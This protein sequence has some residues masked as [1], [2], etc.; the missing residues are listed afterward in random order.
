V[1]GLFVGRLIELRAKFIV[2]VDE[3]VHH[4]E[5]VGQALAGRQPQHRAIPSVSPSIRRFIGFFGLPLGI[6]A[7]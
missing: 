2:A 7:A 6:A 5:H 3:V 4:V 1:G